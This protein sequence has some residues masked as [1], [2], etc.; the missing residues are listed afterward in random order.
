MKCPSL[1]YYAFEGW[2][3]AGNMKI[4]VRCKVFVVAGIA[5]ASRFWL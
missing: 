2:G 1:I 3:V 4:T 5:H